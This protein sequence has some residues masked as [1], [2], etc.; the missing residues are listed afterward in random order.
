MK[1]AVP[2]V[3]SQ[4]PFREKKNLLLSAQEMLN[5]TENVQTIKSS[6]GRLVFF[7]ILLVISQIIDFCSHSEVKISFSGK[8]RVNDILIR[9]SFLYNGLTSQFGVSEVVSSN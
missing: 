1:Y 8:R 7:L 6:L 4:R 3:F 9:L 2:E 5:G